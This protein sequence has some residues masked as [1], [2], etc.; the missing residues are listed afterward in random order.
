LLMQLNALKK[1]SE[2]GNGTATCRLVR[3][4]NRCVDYITNANFGKSVYDALA[5]NQETPSDDFLIGF[6][7]RQEWRN[8]ASSG[9]C[10]GLS[11]SDLPETSRVLEQQ[12]HQLSLRQKVVLVLTQSDGSLRRIQRSGSWS[13]SGAYLVPQYMADN[14]EIFL[15]QGFRAKDPL[16]LEGL[17]LL[18][19][20]SSA[21]RP[22]SPS[23][24]LP[25]PRKFLFYSIVL[26]EVAGMEFAG[27]TVAQLMAQTSLLLGP[28]EVDRT[29]REASLEAATWRSVPKG[30]TFQSARDRKDG[31]DEL[32]GC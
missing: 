12:V 23:V 11:L 30:R 28:A 10:A 31:W 27:S 25:N 5:S 15:Q 24:W 3:M 20:P 29:R 6:I 1:L 17:V 2:S 16:A 22:Q 26:A 13:Q 4:S 14:T 8:K 7:A 32:D 18:Y 9:F 21:F 19:S